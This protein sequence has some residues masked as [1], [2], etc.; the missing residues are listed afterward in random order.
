MA[1][2]DTLRRHRKRVLGVALLA[3]S[4]WFISRIPQVSFF[5]SGRVRAKPVT[6]LL[7]TAASLPRF[8][9]SRLTEVS[10]DG[11]TFAVP[12]GAP[13]LSYLKSLPG[14]AIFLSRR[15]EFP[16]GRRV[17]LNAADPYCDPLPIWREAMKQDPAGGK[18]RALFGE[19]AGG[20]VWKALD[21]V[22]RTTPAELHLWVSEQ[23]SFRVWL[24]LYQKDV[25]LPD[26]LEAVSVLRSPHAHA[27]HYRPRGSKGAGW[28][29]VHG[30]DG[31]CTSV[32]IAAL[33]GAPPV[34]VDELGT[35]LATIRHTE[36]P[37]PREP[38]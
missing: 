8:D 6:W 13:S 10:K 31:H 21:V 11:W 15:I 25:A 32:T 28:A 4:G 23:E 2:R 27:I 22:L 24:L 9:P 5:W 34:T 12:W 19:A 20:D 30:D 35:I 26:D 38:S 14:A 36:S 17:R 29:K 18:A 3:A 1:I 37:A 16:D 33:D 7:P